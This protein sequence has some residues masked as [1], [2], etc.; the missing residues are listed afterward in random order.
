MG[1]GRLRDLLLDGPRYPLG[2]NLDCET[3]VI[4]EGRK[5]DRAVD[6]DEVALCDVM[7]IGDPL[8]ECDYREEVRGTEA[9][10]VAIRR[11]RRLKVASAVFGRLDLSANDVA[12]NRD[13]IHHLLHL[14]RSAAVGL[15]KAGY[16]QAAANGK[17]RG[18]RDL[19]RPWSLAL[20]AQYEQSK[21]R[22]LPAT[23]A[24]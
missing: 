21:R 13:L 17:G 9:F 8:A 10:C 24:Q 6:L 7:Q 15:M 1:G 22:G 5:P 11:D 4:A 18:P 20:R 14:L 2:N 3:L 19:Q 16:A 23:M 12:V